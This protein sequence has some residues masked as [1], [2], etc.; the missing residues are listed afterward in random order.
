MS[1]IHLCCVLQLHLLQR[2]SAKI[3]CSSRD[4]V[5]V[6]VAMDEFYLP[7]QMP[8]AFALS[9]GFAFS[10]HETTVEKR[11]IS[12]I[13]FSLEVGTKA[14]PTPTSAFLLM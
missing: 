14:V 10:G 9:N 6:A 5:Y 8:P 11:T 1:S 3:C 2:D 7:F 13:D 12:Q 4:I